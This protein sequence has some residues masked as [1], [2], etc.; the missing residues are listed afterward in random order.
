VW[1]RARRVAAR[2]ADDDAEGAMARNG[3]SARA[4]GRRASRWS[5]GEYAVAPAARATRERRPPYAVAPDDPALAALRREVASRLRAVCA[6]MD[7]AAF[8]GMVRDV[9][10]FKL[11]W[12]PR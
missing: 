6:G 7:A 2:H 4:A 10:A 9:A 8:E 5:A 1:V 3:T 11:R 12:A